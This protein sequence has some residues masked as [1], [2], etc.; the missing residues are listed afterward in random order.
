MLLWRKASCPFPFT[1]LWALCPAL[2]SSP[3]AVTQRWL[4]HF[5]AS[6]GC[7]ALQ[8]TCLEVKLLQ[9]HGCMTAK[10][11]GHGKSK[12]LCCVLGSGFTLLGSLS[13]S[14]CLKFSFPKM[15]SHSQRLR[16]KESFLIFRAARIC[17]YW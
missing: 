6:L 4:S 15:Y 13:S 7:H 8:S 5:A 11:C 16:V 3:P 14:S 12:P 9:P 17:S 1:L 2:R 10:Q